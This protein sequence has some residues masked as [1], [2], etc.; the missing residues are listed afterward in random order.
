MNP[1]DSSSSS[2]CYQKVEFS[3]GEDSGAGSEEGLDMADEPMKTNPHRSGSKRSRAAEVHN[4]SEKRRRSRINEKMKALQNLIPNSNKT[5]KASMLDEAIEYLKQL[6]L[7]V[8]MLSMRNG[9][10]SHPMYLPSSLHSLQASQMHMNFG[11]NNT[12]VVNLAVLGMLPPP[13]QNSSINA[14]FDLTIRNTV[15]TQSVVLPST[16]ISA[17]ET[18]YT[19]QVPTEDMYAKSTVSHQ[20]LHSLRSTVDIPEHAVE[21]GSLRYGGEHLANV[22]SKDLPDNSIFN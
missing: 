19:L 2:A 3:N 4:M 12:S 8:Q 13:N 6:Q 11:E 7:Q 18:S 16:S 22:L 21:A 17:A 5:D 15:S 14:S 1:F 10:N 20:N 9:L